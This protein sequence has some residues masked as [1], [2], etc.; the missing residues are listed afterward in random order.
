MKVGIIGGG[1]AGFFS[2]M[3]VKENYPNADVII[4]EKSRKVL[5]K[6]KISGGG[7]C[8]V[9]NGCTSIPEL[10]KAYPRGGRSLK[11]VFHVFSTSDTMKWF[12]S[13]GVPLVVQDDNCV[14]PVSQDSQS[15]IDCFL[16]ECRRLGVQIITHAGINAIKPKAKGLELQ[17]V[18]DARKPEQFDKVIVTTGGSPTLIGLK[19]LQELGHKIET[20]VPSLFTFNMPGEKVRKLMGVVVENAMVAIQGTKLKAQG[21]LL[22]TH[23]G[24]SGPAILK[25]S[26]FGA[27]LINETNYH[28]KFQVNWC[29]EQRNDVVFNTLQSIAEQSPNKVLANVKP[30]GLSERL[31]LFL[32]EKCELSSR[33]KWGELGKKGMNKLTNILVNDIYSVDGSSKFREEFV[34]CGGVSLQSINLNTMESKVCDNLYFA[35]EVLDIDAITGGY[36]LQAAWSTG[37]VAGQL[38]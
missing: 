30:Y 31:W 26:A 3:A 33:K 22:I 21:P 35:G 25:L 32:L 9:T 1:A 6:V 10:L 20:P 17:F 7:R 18:D 15:I 4:F 36:N 5:S 8:N 37:F 23:W 14:F 12:K 38:K 34:T 29:N 28:F 16:K 11:K 27:R 2:A 24:M 13:R 19:W